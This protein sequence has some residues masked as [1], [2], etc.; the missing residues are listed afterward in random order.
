[1]TA[2]GHTTKIRLLLEIC[3]R[4]PVFD[5]QKADT[6]L[7]EIESLFQHRRPS[8]LTL[9]RL[10]KDC[11]DLNSHGIEKEYVDAFVGMVAALEHNTAEFFEK[12]RLSR[13]HTQVEFIAFDF[14]LLCR[15]LG[16]PDEAMDAYWGITDINIGYVDA[17]KGVFA[18]A[19]DCLALEDALAAERNLTRFHRVALEPHEV[20]ALERL[21][22]LIARMAT[23]NIPQLAVRAR[24]EVAAAVLRAAKEPIF[25]VELGIGGD[26]RISYAFK[27]RA[28]PEEVAVLNTAIARSKANRSDDI[29]AQLL[30]VSCVVDREPLRATQTTERTGA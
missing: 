18:S 7:D 9:R 16:Y 13:L 15:R 22:Y 6:V 29:R 21:K 8:E 30:T 10:R 3:E 27:L 23:L 28:P 26:D 11:L 24:V 20:D 2:N 17:S 12:F 19:I 14:A 4:Y 25:G 1:M 5:T